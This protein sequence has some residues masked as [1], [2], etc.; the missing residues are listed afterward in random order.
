V[1]LVVALEV[2]RRAVERR[3]RAWARETTPGPPVASGL[4]G[5]QPVVLVQAGMG[6]ARARDA[7][8]LVA[9]RF[10]CP[11][12]WSLGLAGGLD[13]A[14]RPG[15]LVL[16][17]SVLVP[18]GERFGCIVPDE[19]RAALKDLPVH[20]G[21]LASVASPALTRAAK[22]AIRVATSA[23]ALDMEA[24]G[25]AAAAGQLGLSWLALKA[26]LDPADLTLPN[27]LLAGADRDGATRRWAFLVQ[28]LRPARLAAAAHLAQMS[29]RALQRLALAA[30]RAAAAWPAP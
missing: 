22:Q 26:V 27:F 17:D 18:G 21:P 7:A 8:L 9:R 1:A 20:T 15:D 29:R 12:V 19:L 5:G 13:P 23:V 24:A 30:E 28:A 3:L 11:S 2:E 6:A 16:P 25:V 10:G 4:L 14:L